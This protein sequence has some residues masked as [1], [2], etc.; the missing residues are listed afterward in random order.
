MAVT[1]R[2]GYNDEIAALDLRRQAVWEQL[3]TGLSLGDGSAPINRAALDKSFKANEV[4]KADQA[5]LA[6]KRE[7]N[8]YPDCPQ[9]LARN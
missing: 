9:Q 3:V 6:K 5:N 2:I 1:A 4:I 7:A 8:Q